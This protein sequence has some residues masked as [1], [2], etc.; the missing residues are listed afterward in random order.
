MPRH[1]LIQG[2]TWEPAA[3]SGVLQVVHETDRRF[4]LEIASACA[5]DLT[6]DFADA[7]ERIGHLIR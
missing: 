4:D 2:L 1:L 6:I 7:R 3:S 5:A